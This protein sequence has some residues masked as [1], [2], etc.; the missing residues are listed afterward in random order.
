MQQC[1]KSVQS[2][3]LT[4]CPA[5]VSRSAAA[6]CHS[7]TLCD[8]SIRPEKEEFCLFSTSLLRRFAQFVVTWSVKHCHMRKLK[9]AAANRVQ[10]FPGGQFEALNVGNQRC[11][12]VLCT[13]HFKASCR[14]ENMLKD[15]KTRK[16]EL[17]RIA[18]SF[19]CSLATAA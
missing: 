12:E 1:G 10:K 16:A 6:S 14:K 5:S 13:L 2:L 18:G 9:K 17:M 15:R 7:S 11:C 4:K 8:P 3:P 19:I